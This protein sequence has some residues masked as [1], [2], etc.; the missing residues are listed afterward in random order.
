MDQHSTEL[1]ADVLTRLF[2]GDPLTVALFDPDDLRCKPQRGRRHL[3][4][5]PWLAHW[6]HCPGVEADKAAGGGIV[7]ATLRDGIRCKSHVEAVTALCIDHDAGDVTPQQAFAAL[8]KYRLVLHTTASHRLGAPRWRA[9]IALTR[10]ATPAEYARLWAH[11]RDALAAAGVTID[12]G[13]K[14]PCRL[15]YSPT[16]REFGAPFEHFAQLDAAPLDVDHVLARAAERS[17]PR[18]TSPAPAPE[19]RDRYVQGA[20]RCAAHAIA[21]A[22]PG[23]RHY[24]L[25]REA[26]GLARLGLTVSEITAALLP[27]FVIAA[28]EARRA[29]GARTIADAVRARGAA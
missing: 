11:V 28:G 7:F 13:T 5:W 14:D 20:L 27:A 23:E 18:S 10:E 4:S 3:A 22:S 17:A 16:I 12:A 6:T 2:P 24:A 26:F 25:S 19:H 9:I 8:S 21:N 1:G 15:W 29:E